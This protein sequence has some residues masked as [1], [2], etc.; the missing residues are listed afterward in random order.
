MKLLTDSQ[1]KAQQ[2]LIVDLERQL[3][4]RDAE[5]ESLTGQLSA[6][7]QKADDLNEKL[8]D[9]EHDH[10]VQAK[11]QAQKGAPEGAQKHVHEY[12]MPREDVQEARSIREFGNHY[13]QLAEQRELMGIDDASGD[14]RNYRRLAERCFD[15][16]VQQQ[17]R[18]EHNGMERTL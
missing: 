12:R 16:D 5:V 9:V 3:A 4:V 8:I 15:L 7:E 18:V 11:R 10:E 14:G 13:E 2:A 6:A 1:W 17:K